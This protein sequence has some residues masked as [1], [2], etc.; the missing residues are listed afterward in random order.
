MEVIERNKTINLHNFLILL[1]QFSR[2]LTKYF[3]ERITLCIYDKL[4]AF[5]GFTKKHN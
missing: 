4:N 5:P 3:K 2:E 1:H